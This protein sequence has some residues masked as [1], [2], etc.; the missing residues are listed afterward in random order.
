MSILGGNM[1]IITNENLKVEYENE[2]S[3]ELH[4]EIMKEKGYTVEKIYSSVDMSARNHIWADYSKK[5]KGYLG[6]SIYK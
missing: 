3:R 1:M 5:Q 4:I 2:E 6:E